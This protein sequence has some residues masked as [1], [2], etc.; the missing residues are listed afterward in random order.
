MYLGRPQMPLFSFSEAS[1]NH[2]YCL[3]ALVMLLSAFT[4]PT[5]IELIYTSVISASVVR[6]ISRW[7]VR[8]RKVASSVGLVLNKGGV[9]SAIISKLL[10]AN[11]QRN[12]AKSSLPTEGNRKATRHIFH[13]IRSYILVYLRTISLQILNAL[14][15]WRQTSEQP[16]IAIQQGR[17]AALVRS[18]IHLVPVGG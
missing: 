12:S 15:I 17:L 16:K 3:K 7:T 4:S 13:S 11:Q 18:L 6:D 2:F 5:A 10:H 9:F 8:W 14:V 1:I